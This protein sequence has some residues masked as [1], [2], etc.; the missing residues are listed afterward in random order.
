MCLLY[1][2]IIKNIKKIYIDNAYCFTHNKKNS[3]IYLSSDKL[4]VNMYLAFKEMKK[5]KGRFITILLVT[6]LIGYMVY[7]L[8]ALAFGLAESNKTAIDHWNANSI[9][10]TQASNKN[11]YASMILEETYNK[12][13]KEGLEPLNISSAV[14]LDQKSD[15]EDKFDAVFM[16][17]NSNESELMPSI[18]EGSTFNEDLEVVV[19]KD[20]KNMMDIEIGDTLKVATNGRE[21]KIVGFTESSS[22]NTRP[23]VYAKLEMVSQ[24]MMNFTTGGEEDA[25]ATATPNMPKNVSMFIAKDEVNLDNLDELK[26]ESVSSAQFI[27]NIP[28]YQAQ[29]LTFGMMIVALVI[30]A[31]IIIAIFMYIITMQK[32][33]IFAVLKIQGINNSYITKSVIYQT[34]LV[35]LIGS[36]VG[37]VSTIGTI[38]L[39][40]K[41]VPTQINMTLF[42]MIGFLLL[43]F[44]I[45]GS[46]FSAR[47]ILKIDPLDAL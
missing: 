15:S 39:L 26:L 38:L 11:A 34:I 27:N 16:G 13:D 2:N 42:G 25:T 32:R 3:N 21:F 6:A 33:S 40:P 7:F 43:V 18:V 45:V 47:S 36:G 12:L 23:V 10:V 17:V 20:I 5:E 46:I 44:A 41:S 19:S 29:L 1:F 24:V 35:S 31:A 14:I 28:G 22:Y 30:I 8:S 37:L 4:E 9:I